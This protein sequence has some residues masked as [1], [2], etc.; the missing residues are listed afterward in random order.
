MLKRRLLFKKTANFRGKL[1]QNYKQL[2]CKNFK[3]VLK[4]VN[5]LFSVFFQ[6]PWLYLLGLNFSA[7]F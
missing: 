4:Y 6:F 3:V 2:E 1:L 7:G 5:R